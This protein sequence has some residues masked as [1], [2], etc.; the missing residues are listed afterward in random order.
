MSVT[1]NSQVDSTLAKE[2]EAKMQPFFKYASPNVNFSII[3]KYWDNEGISCL[4]LLF[5]RCTRCFVLRFSNREKMRE[6]ILNSVDSYHCDSC[7]NEIKEIMKKYSE[8]DLFVVTK[9]WKKFYERHA[10]DHKGGPY[11]PLTSSP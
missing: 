9:I 5:E 7:K 8:K 11:A 4:D 3:K 2:L 6:L 10:I 1:L